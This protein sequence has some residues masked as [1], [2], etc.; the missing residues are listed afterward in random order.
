MD[1][2]TTTGLHAHFGS[3]ITYA[4]VR[5]TSYP[6]GIQ[7]RVAFDNGR[8]AS[9]IR[10]DS[11]FGDWEVLPMDDQFRDFSGYAARHG[12]V[13]SVLAHLVKIAA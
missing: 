5:A 12:S 3:Q 13:E 6:L 2:L 11:T 9:I 1:T 7:L 8:G 4:N 10:N